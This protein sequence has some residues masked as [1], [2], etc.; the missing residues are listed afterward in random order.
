MYDSFTFSSIIRQLSLCVNSQFMVIFGIA[1]LFTNVTLDEGIS[2]CIDFLYRSQLTSVPSFPESV[3]VELMELAIRSVLM[4]PCTVFQ[5][6]LLLALFLLIFLVGFMKKLLFDRFLKSCIY[7]RYV[8][9][10]FA[11]FSSRNEALSFFYCSNYL[12]PSLIFSMDEEK[13]NKLTFFYVLVE[14]SSFAFVT[15]IHRKS[16]LQ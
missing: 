7:L 6:F 9:N 13:K 10:T 8:D 14:W 2:I 11:C 16:M 15:C 1:S 4:T 5:W 12:H 3:S